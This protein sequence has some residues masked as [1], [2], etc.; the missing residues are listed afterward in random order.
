MAT[1]SCDV[2]EE[3]ATVMNRV[4][5]WTWMRSSL[6][7][8]R[9]V[10]VRAGRRT[11]RVRALSCS[12]LTTVT[13][14]GSF[15]LAEH[16]LYSGVLATVAAGLLMGNLGILAEGDNARIS[17]R[18]REFALALWDFIAFLTNSLIFLLIGVSLAA[19]PFYQVGNATLIVVIVL[20]LLARAVT[21]YPLCLLFAGSR[22]AIALPE[23]HVLW[24]GGLRGALGLALALSLPPSIPLR[25]EILAVTFGAVAFSVL[26]QGL[27]MPLLLRRTGVRS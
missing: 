15:L 23:Q 8:R 24:W 14:Y 25:N 10:P 21:V 13:A 5:F 16:F 12:T 6:R 17:P 18:G 22:W 9:P 27:T 3:W 19:I 2:S 7:I 20:M 26:V 1:D 11:I 4:P